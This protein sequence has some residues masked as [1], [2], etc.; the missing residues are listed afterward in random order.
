MKIQLSKPLPLDPLALLIAEEEVALKHL[1][2]VRAARAALEEQRKKEPQATEAKTLDT[3]DLDFDS[4]T[5]RDIDFCVRQASARK[6]E[7]VRVLV[8]DH[9]FHVQ[10]AAKLCGISI[11]A[12][13]ALRGNDYVEVV[14]AVQGFLTQS[15]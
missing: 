4:L 15:S 13:K 11:D 5:G 6:G 2:A 7:L 14:T 10:I 9:E 3:L 8:M 12:L 1:E